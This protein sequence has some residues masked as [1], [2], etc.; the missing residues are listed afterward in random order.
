MSKSRPTYR[1]LQERLATAEPIVEALKHHEVDAVVGE[2]KITFL[3]LQKVEE[4]LVDSEAGLRVMFDLAGAGL[5]QADAPALRFTRVNRTFCEIVGYS[6]EE[7][8]A[9]TYL[10]LTHPQDRR[11]DM[12]ALARVLRAKADSW[13]IEKRLVRKDGRAIWVAV[14]G[15]VLRDEDG[16]AVRVMA[17]IRDLTACQQ[18]EQSQRDAEKELKKQVRQRTAELTQAIQLLRSQLARCRRDKQTLRDKSSAGKGKLLRRKKA[19]AR[20]R[21]S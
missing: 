11:R 17:M 6:G 19:A 15:A 21:A 16:R 3:L 20:A 18:A 5:V 8:L 12:K 7:L 1:E 9:R 10:D 14:D 2:G 13:S 4:A